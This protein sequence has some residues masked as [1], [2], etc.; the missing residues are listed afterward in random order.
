MKTFL[1]NSMRDQTF[2]KTPNIRSQKLVEMKF[3]NWKS[4]IC[5]FINECIASFFF[6]DNF[7]ASHTPYRKYR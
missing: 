4:S 3:G 1:W 6:F 7:L 5:L 2:L